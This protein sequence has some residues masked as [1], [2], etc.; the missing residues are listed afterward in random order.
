[1]VDS[2][3]LAVSA[4]AAAIGTIFAFGACYLSYK[5]TMAQIYSTNMNF[6]NE[7]YVDIRKNIENSKFKDNEEDFVNACKDLFELLC[8][9]FYLWLDE[10]LPD[11]IYM[12]W[13]FFNSKS[14]PTY[15]Y[16]NGQKSIKVIWS[17]DDNLE[18]FS[19]HNNFVT[20]MKYI[21][22][23]KITEIQKHKKEWQKEWRQK[24]WEE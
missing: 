19:Y 1:M 4:I 18:R 9:E 6:C 23:K 10:R 3:W 7:R 16:K 21:F 14:F 22:N 17:A 2:I 15:V 8:H 11:K 24:K 5:A 12:E 20:C 13:M